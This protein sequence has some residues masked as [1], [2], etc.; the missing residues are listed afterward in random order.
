MDR[1]NPLIV[2]VNKTKQ[3]KLWAYLSKTD[4]SNGLPMKIKQFWSQPYIWLQYDHTDNNEYMT[5]RRYNFQAV[6]K[7][8][9]VKTSRL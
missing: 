2:N 7:M 9:L 4:I 6:Q 5:E 3:S 1:M 8:K